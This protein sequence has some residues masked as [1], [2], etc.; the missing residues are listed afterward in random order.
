MTLAAKDFV[1][2]EMFVRWMNSMRLFD[3]GANFTI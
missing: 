3:R 1:A 2:F